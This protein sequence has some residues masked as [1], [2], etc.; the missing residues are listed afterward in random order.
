VSAFVDLPSLREL[1]FQI[2]DQFTVLGAQLNVRTAVVV[3]GMDMMAQA[4]EL[5]RRP[6]VV[7]A[8]PGRMVDHL[9]STSGDWSLDRVQFL[10]C[11][12]NAFSR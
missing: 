4:I 3:G 7:V 10:V 6:H 9:H 12:S 5:E 2:A 11:P 1:A 8:T